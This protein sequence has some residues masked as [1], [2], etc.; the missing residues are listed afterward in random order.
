MKTKLLAVLC[1]ALIWGGCKKE[2]KSAPVIYSVIGTWTLASYQTNYGI[3]VN[4]NV[5]QY[6]CM[7]YNTLTFYRDSTSSSNY[8][9]L[10]TCFITP[11]HSFASGAQDY[12]I[13]GTFALGSTWHQ[14][15][16]NVYVLYPGNTKAVPGVVS[17]INGQL[18]INFKDTVVSNGK[19]YYIN[20]VE[21]Q[22]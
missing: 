17:S 15:G 2:K 14:S 9:G 21:V 16:N 20:S 12:G 5:S 3:G 13:P 1:A 18:Q 8:D 11:T 19:T 4:A 10:D 7:A 6:P 22:Q